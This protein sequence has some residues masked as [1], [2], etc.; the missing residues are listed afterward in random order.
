MWE[1]CWWFGTKNKLKL[2]D[3][4]KSRDI[5]KREERKHGIAKFVITVGKKLHKKDWESKANLSKNEEQ[6]KY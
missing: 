2:Q 5:Y 4:L 6:C 1:V 3:A